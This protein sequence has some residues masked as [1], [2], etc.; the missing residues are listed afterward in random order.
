MTINDCIAWADNVAPNKFDLQDKLN[1][2]SD[3]ESRIY[4]ELLLDPMRVAFVEE[5]G[6][7]EL[8][9][10]A[11]YDEIYRYGLAAHIHYMNMDYEQNEKAL[12]MFNDAWSRFRLYVCNNVRPAYGGRL[13]GHLLKMV[14]RGEPFFFEIIDIP[15][16]LPATAT[17]VQGSRSSQLRS[18]WIDGRLYVEGDADQTAML[19]IGAARIKVKLHDGVRTVYILN[20]AVRLAV[21]DE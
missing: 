4:S 16:V 13:E 20:R 14:L 2:L 3:I 6:E 5:D 9:V 10:L 15:A 7:Q 1:C 19:D 12:A 17:L 21:R 8:L 18:Q 11:P